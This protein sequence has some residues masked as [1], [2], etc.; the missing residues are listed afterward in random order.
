RPVE[1]WEMVRMISAARIV[2]PSSMTDYLP[3]ECRSLF[4]NK[5]CAVMAGAN[6]I[7][8]GDTLLTTSNMV[9]FETLGL[10]PLEPQSVKPD[11][12]AAV[13]E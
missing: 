6:S 2:M 3:E 4:P 13:V 7:F 1:V 8:T 9:M 12:D 10:M 5:H 11:E